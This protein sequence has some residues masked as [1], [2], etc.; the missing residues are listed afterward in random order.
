[1][2]SLTTANVA[3]SKPIFKWNNNY[4]WTFNGNLAGKTQ[5]KEAVKTAGGKVDGVLRFSMIW[6]DTDQRDGSDLDAWCLQPDKDSIG[7]NTGYRKDSGDRFSSCGGQLDLDNR[8][9]GDK[10]AI[11]NIYFTNLTKLKN[12]V[13][14]FWVNQFASRNSKGFKAEIE[15]DGEIYSYEYNRPVSGNVQVAEVTFK[16]GKFTINHKLSA[17][18]GV[19]ASKEIY[20]LETN[21]FQKV[22]LVCLSPNHWG[23]NNSGNKYYFFML[24]GCKCPTSIR[25]F[26]NENLI[27]DLLLHRKVMEVL[28]ATNMIEPADKQLSG[29]GFNATVR[30]EVIVRLQGTFKRELKIKF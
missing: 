6:N 18:E 14:K 26:H 28:G 24:D 23:D 2:V 30:D 3:D 9:P 11:E 25:S 15:F 10:I 21:Q 4:S 19:G 20:G 27:S 17:T 5:I 7:Y 22:N 16:D 13:Y 12:G 8:F 1:L 29:L